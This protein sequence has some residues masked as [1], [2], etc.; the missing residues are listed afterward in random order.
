MPMRFW[1]YAFRTVVYIL[2]ELPSQSIFGLV[3]YTLIY[4]K[5]PNSTFLRTFGSLCYPCLRA[6]NKHKLQDRSV[7]CVFL[8]NALQDQGNLYLDKSAGIMYSTRHV[9]FY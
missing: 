9:I 1:V 8:G 6:Y 5:Q 2:N 7:P 4:H 3:P